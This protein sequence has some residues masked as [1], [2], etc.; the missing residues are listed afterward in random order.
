MERKLAKLGGGITKMQI[1][2]EKEKTGINDKMTEM[3]QKV[4]YTHC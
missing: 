2:L 3:T 4:A 1:K